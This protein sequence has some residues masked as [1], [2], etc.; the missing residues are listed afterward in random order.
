MAVYIQDPDAF[1]KLVAVEGEEYRRCKTVEY[2]G[3]SSFDAFYQTWLEHGDPNARGSR[4]NIRTTS[5]TASIY[6][7]DGWNRYILRKDGEI[8]FD[9][10]FGDPQ[11]AKETGFNIF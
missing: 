8:L 3:N 11:K 4:E 2:F 5:A 10:S 7:L 6:G 9:E 1:E